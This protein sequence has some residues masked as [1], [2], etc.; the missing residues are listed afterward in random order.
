MCELANS[1]QYLTLNACKNFTLS[2]LYIFP[3]VP[4]SLPHC[5]IK[6][7]GFLLSRLASHEICSTAACTGSTCFTQSGRYLIDEMLNE[8]YIFLFIT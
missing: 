2:I 8:T 5:T 1:I 7:F 6:F 4:P 3:F